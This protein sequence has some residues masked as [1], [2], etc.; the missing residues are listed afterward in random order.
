MRR[1]SFVCTSQK[2]SRRA[3]RQRLLSAKSM[4]RQ[5]E[6]PKL[7]TRNYRQRE[8]KA[9][10]K[11]NDCKQ[12]LLFAVALLGIAEL[13]LTIPGAAAPVVVALGPDAPNTA[14]FR[15]KQHASIGNYRQQ[16]LSAVHFC[17]SR[18]EG[19]LSALRG[20]PILQCELSVVL[21]RRQWA[22]SAGL[23]KPSRE[24]TD[25]TAEAPM[26]ERGPAV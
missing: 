1:E 12:H 20:R 21:N 15:A 24:I 14:A 3:C 2:G 16:A 6:M 5:K 19:A 10:E 17:P 7:V 13:S 23:R 8:I 22:L 25:K 11:P 9:C 26:V 4:H 18:L